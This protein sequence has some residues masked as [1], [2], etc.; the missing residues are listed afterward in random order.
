MDA[1]KSGICKIVC[2]DAGGSTVACGI[3]YGWTGAKKGS[4]DAARTDDLTAILQAQFDAMEPGPKLIMGDL[5]GSLENF[6]TAVALITEHGWADIGNGDHKCQGKPGRTTCYTKEEAKESR[7]D[8]ILANNRMAPAIVK[9]Y[10]DEDSDYPTHRPL[11]IEVLTRLLEVNVKE[12]QTPTN[13][14]NMLEQKIEA[15]LD[16]E[17]KIRDEEILKGNDTYQ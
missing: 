12:L 5:N 10:G 15:E 14:A 6:I 8:F 11:C 2:F 1:E 9:C 3:V 7:I 16:R 13:F 4:K 17:A